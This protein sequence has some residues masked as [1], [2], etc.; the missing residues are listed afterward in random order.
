VFPRETINEKKHGYEYPCNVEI[1][2]N[3]LIKD[4]LLEAKEK[5]KDD[6]TSLGIKCV[7]DSFLGSSI[8][9]TSLCR[10]GDSDEDSDADNVI[11]NIITQE[12]TSEVTQE[13]TSEVITE[14]ERQE[15]E[16]LK[17]QMNRQDFNLKDYST[18]TGKKESQFLKVY[19]NSSNVK[20]IRKSTLCWLFSNKTGR[21]SSDRLLRVRGP[22]T[23][24]TPKKKTI[25]PKKNKENA[26][27]ILNHNETS[28][29]DST[30]EYSSQSEFECENFSSDVDS[31]V[32]GED[33]NKEKFKIIIEKY[34]AV[35]YS[36]QWYIGRILTHNKKKSKIKFLRFN[37]NFFEWPNPAD[38]QLVENQFIFYGPVNIQ[39]SNTFT[40]S[41]HETLKINNKYKI[42]KNKFEKD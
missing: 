36:D 18:Y 1:P 35:Y 32:G 8:P 12:T 34:Y 21:L 15:L 30:E 23:D 6:L 37:L 4:T 7:E 11:E 25:L 3:D 29:E 9:N 17:N 2:S 16:I 14:E 42:L 10:D 5:A 38:I 20:T 39:G 26:K 27:K 41:R 40:I 28:S 33:K 22:T 24:K 13:T 31:D 19:L